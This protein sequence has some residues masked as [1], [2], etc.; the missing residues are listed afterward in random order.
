MLTTPRYLARA[1]LVLAATTLASVLTIGAALGFCRI[2]DSS[3]VHACSQE[4]STLRASAQNETSGGLVQLPS[5]HHMFLECSGD[6]SA[7]PTVI[8]A[9]GRGLGAASDWAKVQEK[10]PQSIR[11]CSYDAIG[12]GRSD[13]YQPHPEAL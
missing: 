2:G 5:G 3:V 4:Q 12:A 1:R 7:V 11:V 9:N 8:L 13:P 6:Q 10:V